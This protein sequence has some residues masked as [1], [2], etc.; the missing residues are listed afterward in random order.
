ML[1]DRVGLR[2]ALADFRGD[3][4]HFRTRL[5]RINT[6]PVPDHDTGDNL[7]ATI[8]Q[9]LDDPETSSRDT[10]GNSGMLIAAWLEGAQSALGAQLPVGQLASAA[11]GEVALTIA[12]P[13]PGLFLDYALRSASLL[14]G[15]GTDPANGRAEIVADDLRMLLI[16][17]AEESAELRQLVDSGSAGLYFLLKRLL[18]VGPNVADEYLFQPSAPP[19]AVGADGDLV[20]FLFTVPGASRDQVRAVLD[21]FTVNSVLVGRGP[22]DGVRVHCHGPRHLAAPLRESML[23]VGGGTGDFRVRRIFG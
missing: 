4:E 23:P 2:G 1:I 15:M 12:Y 10:F 16:E 9:L 6:L 18:R 22:R 11:A 3:L 19:A 7:L 13:R 17:T 8:S 21:R 5:N 14:V 20:E